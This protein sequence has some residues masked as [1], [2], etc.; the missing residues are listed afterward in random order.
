MALATGLA[1][2]APPSEGAVLQR[3]GYQSTA[4]VERFFSVDRKRRRT[5]SNVERYSLRAVLPPSLV[6]EIGQV[7]RPPITTPRRILVQIV[8]QITIRR[9]HIEESREPT[10][11]ASTARGTANEL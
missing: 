11:G 6:A 1:N 8:G 4:E 3:V 10:I 9:H 7:L 5:S 2:L